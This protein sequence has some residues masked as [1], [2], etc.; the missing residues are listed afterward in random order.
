MVNW[1]VRK[2]AI[3]ALV[4]LVIRVWFIYRY[5]IIFGGDTVLR[6]LNYQFIVLSYQLPLPQATVHYLHTL[7][8]D[9]LAVRWFMALL[10]AISGPAFFLLAEKFVPSADAFAGALLFTL[11]PFILPLS[12]VPYQETLMVTGLLFAFYGA[13]ADRPLVASIGLGVACL[14]RYESWLACPVLF[15]WYLKRNGVTLRRVAESAALYGWAPLVWVL[16]NR[17]ITPAGSFAVE[18]QLSVARLMRWAYVGYVT[19]LHTPI[20]IAALAIIGLVI[21][22]KRR[23]WN[24][25]RYIALAA[26]VALFLLALLFS[27]HGTQPDPERRVTDR[28]AHITLVAMCFAATLGLTAIGRYRTVVVGLCTVV[29]LWMAN[30]YFDQQTSAPELA[31]SYR[32]AHFLDSAVASGE[33]VAVLAKPIDGVPLFLGKT[34]SG[35]PAAR[36]AALATLHRLETTPPNFQRILVHSRLGKTQLHSYASLIQR[37]GDREE[38]LV[39]PAVMEHPPNWVARWNDFSPTSHAEEELAAAIRTLQ[40]VWNRADGG[41]SLSIYRLDSAASSASRQ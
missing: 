17:G 2:I 12:T 13:F 19:L 9:P 11:N 23:L 38:I 33:H 1:A 32:A 3:L 24:D 16:Y 7:T 4:G 41:F 18:N 35:Q 5:P 31:I 40:P 26:Y 15:A 22:I 6:L 8:P 25:A 21:F 14:T 29:S 20:P 28:E 30:R 10:G 27:A 34:T 37:D 39:A 36:A